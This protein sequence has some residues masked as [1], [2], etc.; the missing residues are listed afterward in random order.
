MLEIKKNRKNSESAWTFIFVFRM[1]GE[2]LA[3]FEDVVVVA[4][5]Y[6]FLLSYRHLF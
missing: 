3:A 5:N 6:R 4:I 2:R 1:G